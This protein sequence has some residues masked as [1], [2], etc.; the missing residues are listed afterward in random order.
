[1]INYSNCKIPFWTA[2]NVG[3]NKVNLISNGNDQKIAFFA[4]NEWI[5]LKQIFKI[6]A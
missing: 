1:M 3:G 6:F 5:I 2:K 4:T